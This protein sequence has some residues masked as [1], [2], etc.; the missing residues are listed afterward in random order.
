[1]NEL[2]QYARTYIEAGLHIL[3]LNGKRPNN[4][5]HEEWSWE[6]SIHGTV[7]SADDLAGLE[8]VFTHRTTTGIAILVPE[9]VLVADIDTEAAAQLY[10][11]L[12]GEFPTTTPVAR[13]AQG[14]HVWF[15][16]PGADGS[17]W[18]GDRA[19]LFKGFGGY[20]VAEPSWHPG[21]PE[22]GVAAGNHYRWNIP[23]VVD[24]AVR[25][26]EWLPNGIAA[27][28]TARRLAEAT[29]P[30]SPYADEPSR[31][32]TPVTINEGPWSYIGGTLKFTMGF[33][34]GGLERAIIEAADGNQNNVIH[35]AACVARDEGVP[36]E[37][38]MDRLLAAA[39]TGNH[40]V[41][42]AKDSIRGA[43]KKR[44]PK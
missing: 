3:A 7:E 20:V 14:L 38:A 43:Y 36:F 8:A 26:I 44:G 18:L 6:D 17:V 31:W 10:M 1:M 32:L 29:K 40:P 30:V 12:A 15:L 24:G 23:L 41:E 42:R 13:T 22:K 27:A 11:D 35:W 39:V 9:H 33:N 34:L 2:T 21:A 37:V 28:L 19:L 16:A 25:G 5:F 4:V